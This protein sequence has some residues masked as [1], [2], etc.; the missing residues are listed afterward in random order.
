MVSKS[1]YDIFAQYYDDL[2]YDVNYSEI[3][4]YVEGILKKHSSH[5]NNQILELG[6]GTGKI[7]IEFAQRGFDV[8]GIDISP[9]MLDSATKNSRKNGTDV[10]FI[11]QDMTNFELHA[12][13]KVGTILCL[14]DS[15][16]HITDT[17]KL[18]RM[19]K[20]VKKYLVDGGLFIF[21]INSPYKL[22]NILGNNFFYYID[23]DVSYLWQ[24]QLNKR[25]NVVRFDLTFFIKSH[26]GLYS[27]HDVLIK[28]KIFQV[29]ELSEYLEAAGLSV[30]A[31]YGDK[32]FKKPGKNEKR[33]F[34]VAKN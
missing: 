26:D 30:E 5:Q 23:D 19:F 13:D 12:H 25:N 4:D 21:D 20:L 33:I 10:L 8:I 18:K 3:A 17:R 16:N 2:M 22:K 24:N 9:E 34:I 31:V 28:E 7:C 11:N 1:G 27:R 29:E 14:M 32:T 15:V 6:C